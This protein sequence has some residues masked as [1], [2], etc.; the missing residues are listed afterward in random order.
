MRSVKPELSHTMQLQRNAINVVQI[1]QIVGFLSLQWNTQEADGKYRS[2]DTQNV[3]LYIVTV[4]FL[5]IWTPE[6]LL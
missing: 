3:G 4:K 2:V 5:N 6:K 1:M